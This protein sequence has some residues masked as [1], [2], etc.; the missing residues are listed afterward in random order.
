MYSLV[1]AIDTGLESDGSAPIP[2]L[3]EQMRRVVQAPAGSMAQYDAFYWVVE[4]DNGQ[5]RPLPLV[6]R[7]DRDALHRY[8]CSVD[9]VPVR[10]RSDVHDLATKFLDTISRYPRLIVDRS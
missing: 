1:V 8:L 9:D 4:F 2:S 3:A 7:F 6:A 5:R 10:D